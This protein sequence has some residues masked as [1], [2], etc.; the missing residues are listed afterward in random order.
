[1]GIHGHGEA[2]LLIV[3]SLVVWLEAH[4]DE[5]DGL[6]PGRPMLPQL[7]LLSDEQLRAAARSMDPLAAAE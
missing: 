1:V 4:A 3:Q 5:V 7:D 6:D 2:N